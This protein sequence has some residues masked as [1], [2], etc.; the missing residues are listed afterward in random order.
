MN[1]SLH[2]QADLRTVREILEP[3]LW[4]DTSA[5]LWSRD[6]WV[7]VYAEQLSDDMDDVFELAEPL[8]LLSTV[9]VASPEVFEYQGGELIST[10]D[11]LPFEVSEDFES[12]E[13]HLP[14]G[15]IRFE[16]DAS[17]PGMAE[18]FGRSADE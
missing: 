1:M 9:F 18:F 15:A 16:R 12:L 10:V 11:A 6:N 4:P 13:E 8:S 3:L 7:S 17:K 5:I 2:L 14:P